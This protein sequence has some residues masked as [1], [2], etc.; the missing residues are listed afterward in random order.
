MNKYFREVYICD[1][2]TSRTT[3][4]K[5]TK[6]QSSAASSSYEE[7]IVNRLLLLQ[8]RAQVTTLSQKNLSVLLL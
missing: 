1:V 4:C 7:K 2:D 6:K 5:D 3:S 8:Q